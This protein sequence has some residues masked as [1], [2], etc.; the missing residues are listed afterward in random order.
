M[1]SSAL[2]LEDS[3]DHSVFDMQ[4]IFNTNDDTFRQELIKRLTKDIYAADEINFLKNTRF[5]QSVSDPI[6][7]RL[8]PFKNTRQKKLMFGLPNKYDC[9]KDIR[10]WM[11]EGY[12]ILFN[13]KCLSKFDIKVICGYLTTQY[14]L[15]S[16]ARPDFS[17]L[18]LLFID[19]AHDGLFLSNK[20]KPQR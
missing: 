6:L 7:N 8:D 12:I 15:T 5:N 4:E 18:H 2:N 16:L 19:E 1:M 14:Y 10:K 3:E 9:V 17:M 13:L 20:K 11:D